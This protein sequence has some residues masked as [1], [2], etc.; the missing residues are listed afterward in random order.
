MDE[1]TDDILTYL[2]RYAKMN[3]D[4]TMRRQLR[5]YKEK[6]AIYVKKRT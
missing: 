5:I 6:G 4:S 3:P 1:I 2:S